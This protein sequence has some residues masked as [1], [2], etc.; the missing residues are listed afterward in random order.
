[1]LPYLKATDSD[2]QKKFFALKTRADVADLLEVT[3]GYLKWL[4]Y[5]HKAR[6]RYEEKKIKK[7]SGGERRLFSPPKNLHILQDK[8]LRVLTI[9]Y[10]PK[11]CVTGFLK[12]ESILR[13]ARPHV[14]RVATFNIDLQDFFPTIHIGRVRGA[15]CA[16]P[17]GL[18]NSAATVIGQL[19][20]HNDGH[21]PQGAPTSPII[22]NLVCGP[23]DT[24]LTVLAKKHQCTYTRY[25]DDITFSTTKR[26]FPSDI[27]NYSTDTPS[28]GD[29][30]VDIVCS[31]FR[32]TIRSEKT[33][34]QPQSRRQQ[35]TGLVVNEMPNVPRRY[36]RDLRALLCDAQSNGLEAAAIKHA[37]CR[38]LPE[39]VATE[40]WISSVIVGK[41]GYLSM[42]RGHGSFVY[43]RMLREAHRLGLKV[44]P[45]LP[46]AQRFSETL[47]GRRWH[48]VDWRVWVRRYT[49]SVMRLKCH[50]GVTG[51]TFYGSAFATATHRLVSAAHSSER[52]MPGGATAVLALSL[53]LPSGEVP[54]T[55]ACKLGDFAKGID[56][57]CESGLAAVGKVRPGIPTQ[58]RIPEVGE[59]VAAIGYPTLPR[60]QSSLVLHVG[61]IEAVTNNYHGVVHLSVSFP[62][63]L[64]LSGAPLLDANGYCLGV[65]VENTVLG[66]K[67]VSAAEDGDEQDDGKID[68]LGRAYGQAVAIA[69]WRDVPG[70][71]GVF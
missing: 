6:T 9:V 58:E 21:L 7:K 48:R 22:A 44:P 28:A 34:L 46:P 10:R 27:V 68:V 32:F 57:L 65:M 54:L 71:A 37:R 8:L 30:L 52:K 11:P 24:A 64:G 29:G 1:M 19:V 23:L 5:F 13:N 42:V 2:L 3:D 39:E 66:E 53:D 56:I 51:D 25:A 38:G 18:A 50:D 47:R 15:L 70:V 63:G 36:F 49:S 61:T 16:P 33:R 45:V 43:L 31:K 62:S 4:L 35:V 26:S 55:P 14:G 12:N 20:C 60:R 59:E 67:S 40:K 69:H 17:F 41:L